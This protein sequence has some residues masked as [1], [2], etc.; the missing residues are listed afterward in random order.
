MNWM[1][2]KMNG[3]D[4]N[5]C[6]VVVNKI[7]YTAAHNHIIHI[8][9]SFFFRTLFLKF[10]NCM[11]LFYVFMFSQSF[12]LVV[13]DISNWVDLTTLSSSRAQS[14]RQRIWVI[15]IIVFISQSVSQR[16]KSASQPFIC[17]LALGQ[18]KSIVWKRYTIHSLFVVRCVLCKFS[19]TI[20]DCV[21]G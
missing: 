11:I 13:N 9:N 3:K 20:R 6:I 17:R 2:S 18:Q 7:Y 16:V 15:V 10:V 14:L 4:E 5:V 19:F 21:V 1:E 12:S 8:Y